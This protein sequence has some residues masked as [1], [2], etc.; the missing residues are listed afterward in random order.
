[1]GQS[2]SRLRTNHSQIT[3]ISGLCVLVRREI[4]KSRNFRGVGGRNHWRMTHESRM[5]RACIINNHW[6]FTEISRTST[7]TSKYSA[8][9]H[10]HARGINHWRSASKHACFV[11]V[12]HTS[13]FVPRWTWYMRGS[14]VIWRWSVSGQVGTCTV[15]N[16]FRRIHTDGR[17]VSSAVTHTRIYTRRLMNNA[18]WRKIA[19][20]YFFKR[21][22]I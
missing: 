10:E 4:E 15:S 1:M 20:E 5:N 7:Q 3:H 8:V 21:S 12:P 22:K 13:T 6:R 9:F 2:H 19:L 14:C 17:C 18:H 11:N 16:Q